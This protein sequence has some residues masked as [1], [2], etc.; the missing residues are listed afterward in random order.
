MRDERRSR[1]AYRKGQQITFFFQVNKHKKSPQN[2]KPSARIHNEHSFSE[3]QK[4]SAW[5]GKG[6][7]NRS[8]FR[9]TKAMA[10]GK[11]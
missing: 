5:K 4:L 2:P 1:K 9:V 3:K 10:N 11:E 7:K 6:I 8:D